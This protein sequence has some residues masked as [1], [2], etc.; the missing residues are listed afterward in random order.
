MNDRQLATERDDR[1]PGLWPEVA[2]ARSFLCILAQP[3]E[4]PYREPFAKIPLTALKRWLIAQGLGPLAYA[5]FKSVWPELAE[6]LRGDTYAAALENSMRLEREARICRAFAEVGIPV[7][8][9]KGAALAHSVYENPAWRPMSDLD[10]WVRDEQMADALQAMHEAGFRAKVSSIER[11]PLLQKLFDG[12]IQFVDSDK[13]LVE[14]HWSPFS[15]WWLQGAATVDNDGLWQRLEPLQRNPSSELPEGERESGSA[16]ADLFQL[17]A[18]DVILQLAV[19]VSI[20]HKFGIWPVRSLL[21]IT[22][23][24]SKRDVDWGVVVE[25]ARRWRLATVVWTVLALTQAL[26]DLEELE[27]VL[28][29]LSPSPLRRRLLRRL[30]PLET[31]LADSDL[32][33]SSSRFP[34][35][36]L[37]VDRPLDM[38]RLSGRM[39]W[40]NRD[41]LEARYGDRASRRRHLWRVVRERQI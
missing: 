36:L 21:D 29:A 1:R 25:R 37:L 27:P 39:L 32:R 24:A 4:Q 9:L 16:G 5:R 2:T 35:L 38:V 8:L 17:A 14:L 22:L 26:F 19:H 28:A 31:L 3:A 20:N 6:A 34:L 40:P 18:E 10:L 23:V 30:M 7:V 41:W 15:G 13:G 12:E 11:P 33:E